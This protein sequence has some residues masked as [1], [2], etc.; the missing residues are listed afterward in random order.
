MF[1]PHWEWWSNTRCPPSS[2][3]VSTNL[4]RE[5]VLGSYPTAAGSGNLFLWLAAAAYSIVKLL[6]TL[7]VNASAVV[8]IIHPSIDSHPLIPGSGRGGS[9]PSRLTQTSLS[10]ATFSSSHSGGSRGVPKPAGRCNPSSVSWV[11]P[12]VSPQLDVPGKPLTGGVQ[13]AFESVLIM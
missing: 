7:V 9:R 5:S 3:L 6:H 1:L 12:G 11:F 13:E 8:L 4:R 10:P 2:A